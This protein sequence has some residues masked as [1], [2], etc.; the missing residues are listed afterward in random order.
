MVIYQYDCTTFFISNNYKYL[1]SQF[2][3][4]FNSTTR[5]I[6]VNDIND[7]PNKYILVTLN[8]R[9]DSIMPLGLKG[10]EVVD[11]S[12]PNGINILYQ[13]LQGFQPYK[14]SDVA[15]K[16]P[17]FKSQLIT[18]FLPVSNGGL[19]QT[20]VVNSVE[21]KLTDGNV[22]NSSFSGGLCQTAEYISRFKVKNNTR[23]KIPTYRITVEV[24]Q[25]V[26]SEQMRANSDNGYSQ[27]SF[28]EKDLYP[29]ESKQFSTV[30]KIRHGNARKVLSSDMTIKVYSD[31]GVFEEHFP[32]QSFFKI[33]KNGYQAVTPKEEDFGDPYLF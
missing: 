22:S 29:D 11:L 12:D 4:R 23:I 19:A 28:D 3:W 7:S 6:V 30:L 20:A 16:Q 14:F 1:L 13:K 27:I 31:L 17:V 33:T 18:P 25:G 26:F 9:R 32:I 15:N 2:K 21:I 8:G 24:P 10:R 5:N